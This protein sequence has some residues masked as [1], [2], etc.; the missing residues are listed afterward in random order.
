M[1]CW[2]AQIQ[3]RQ[4]K[5][6]AKLATMALEIAGPIYVEQTQ[7][8]QEVRND[9]ANRTDDLDDFPAPT[10]AG[11][12]L[13][14]PEV[15]DAPQAAPSTIAGPAGESALAGDRQSTPAVE[16]ALAGDKQSA[17]PDGKKRP[18]PTAANDARSKRHK[19][20]VCLLNV[21]TL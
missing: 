8:T 19:T 20:K 4:R 7:T 11:S 18:N 9:F 12:Q 21:S 17:Q 14:Q 13:I 3:L 5:L 10:N 6:S 15:S 1:K 2:N 16:N